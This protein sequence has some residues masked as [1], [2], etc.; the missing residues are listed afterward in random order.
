M[1]I[2]F[3]RM[4]IQDR[5]LWMRRRISDFG[6]LFQAVRASRAG[7][8]E[9]VPRCLRLVL[10][11][12][13]S[14]TELSMLGLLGSAPLIREA[15]FV[16]K[17]QMLARQ[18]LVNPRA[19]FSYTENKLVFFRRCVDN[20]LATPRV[21]AA[22]CRKPCNAGDIPVV[23]NPS[24]LMG[25]LAPAA[26]CDF[27]F[28]P[29]AGVH[30]EGVRLF[31][32]DGRI[33]TSPD[34]ATH[35]AEDIFAHAAQSRYTN[36]IFQDRLRPHRD[37]AG[38]SGSDYLQTARVVSYVDHH[39][40]ARVLIAWLR[41]IGGASVFDNY[42]FGTSG[43]LVGTIDVASGR[44]EHVLAPGQPGVGL[45]ERTHHPRTGA[46]F[47]DFTIPFMREICEL[48]TRAARA[49]LPLRTIGWDVGITDAGPSLIEGNVTWDPLPTRR[50]LRA[51][52]GSLQ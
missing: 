16:S 20:G 4:P 43:N 41:I 33:F 6:R 32:Y 21:F 28:K 17:R 15:T 8:H 52:A 45:V 22:L 18:L 13:Y 49:F 47:S 50:N 12:K 1:G 39:G 51:I 7:V 10:R 24:G 35:S 37:L 23:E 9:A 27:I 42:N 25:L 44:L 38:L 14:P 48:V 19:C 30:G 11:E 46:A 2:Y 34:G 40:E 5:I 3:A 26:P 31:R 36:W 29:V